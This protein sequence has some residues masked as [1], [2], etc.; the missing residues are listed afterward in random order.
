MTTKQKLDA[1]VNR[2]SSVASDLN[3]KQL[4]VREAVSLQKELL[5]APS[6]RL[7]G[8]VAALA[9]TVELLT[10]REISRYDIRDYWE[11]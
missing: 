8:E 7:E 10:S 5:D 2:P 4:L 11:E 9:R 3:K 6:E 1:Y